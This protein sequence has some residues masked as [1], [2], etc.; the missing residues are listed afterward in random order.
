MCHYL[1]VAVLVQPGHIS[2]VH[3]EHPTY[4]PLVGEWQDNQING[5]GVLEYTKVLHRAGHGLVA[6]HC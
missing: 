1:E 6:A 4:L 2:M 5:E 3:H